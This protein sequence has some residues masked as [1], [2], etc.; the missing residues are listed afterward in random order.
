MWPWFFL[1]CS[2][3]MSSPAAASATVR[4]IGPT[5]SWVSA[6]GACPSCE[7]RPSVGRIVTSE[8]KAAG[9]RSEPP[10]SV[11]IA[12]GAYPAATLAAGPPLEPPTVRVVSYGFLMKPA[13]VL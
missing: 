2:T 11:P 5:V 10:V 13:I 8:S 6:R 4:A 7:T 12:S 9:I 3:I 1:L